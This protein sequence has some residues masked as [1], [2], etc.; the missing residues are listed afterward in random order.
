M[1]DTATVSVSAAEPRDHL[2]WRQLFAAYG[3]F[4]EV[5]LTG[6]EIDRAWAWI[7]DPDR[8]ARCLI[9]RA[10]DGTPVGF[11]HY[12]AEDSPLSGTRGF[13]DDLFVDPE[14]RGSGAVDA[15]F[16]EL[17]RI[18]AAE[19][20]PNVRWRTAENNYRAR[21]VYDRHGAK[22]VFLTYSMDTAAPGAES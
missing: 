13:L 18:A 21:G 16:A 11:A 3:K 4:Y 1:I 10:E 17:R 5:E 7:H 6:A 15:L 20:W 14:H 12:R 22:T 9:A 2:V 19:G 8:T